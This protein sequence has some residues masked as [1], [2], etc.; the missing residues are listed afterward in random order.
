MPLVGDALIGISGLLIAY[1]IL[2]NTGL[3]AWTVIIAWNVVA[4]GM[5]CLHT[6]CRRR[7]HG[8]NSS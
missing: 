7:T 5:H 2:K 4:I 6:W 1:L 3:L 8:L